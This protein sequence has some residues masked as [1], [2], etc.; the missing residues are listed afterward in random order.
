MVEETSLKEELEEEEIEQDQY[1]VFTVKGQEFGIQAMRI[2]EITAMMDI[3]DVPNAPVHIEGILN[4]RG[5]LV[6]AVNFRKR[7]HFELKE[8]DE[9]TR[10]I[11]MEHEGFP[12]GIIVDI[13]EEVIKIPAA[14]VQQ[15][16]PTAT[17]SLPDGYI[18]GVGM[19][20]SRLVILLDV[21]KV[22]NKTDLVAPEAMHEA[23]EKLREINSET[24][25]KRP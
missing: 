12:V 10:I 20:D 24:I 19:L 4:L 23:I 8:Q 5:R 11:I 22:L 14:K 13:V 9:D 17:S 1:L 2:Q 6:S 18:T 25:D 3:A 7:F 16:P 15:I 21:D